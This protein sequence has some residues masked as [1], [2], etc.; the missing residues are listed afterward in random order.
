M[1]NLPLRKKI[2]KGRNPKEVEAT[3]EEQSEVGVDLQE[4][5]EVGGDLLTE[6]RTGREKEEK[7]MKN[8]TKNRVLAPMTKEEGST[9]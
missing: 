8:G 6:T 7:T 1:M 5:E 2:T 4:E 9:G 3:V